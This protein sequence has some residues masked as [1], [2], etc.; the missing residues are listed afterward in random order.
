MSA[1]ASLPKGPLQ[2]A[3]VEAAAGQPPTG[4][5]RLKELA[6][7][8]WM[9][10]PD[11]QPAAHKSGPRTHCA[12]PFGVA[13]AGAAPAAAA[14]AGAAAAGATGPTASASPRPSSAA[15]R[16]RANSVHAESA[17]AASELS[18]CTPPALDA[19]AW[20]WGGWELGGRERGFNLSRRQAVRGTAWKGVEGG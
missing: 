8:A 17:A 14:G 18:A 7:Q 5:T 3:G 15:R 13:A 16:R 20:A 9:A 6:S 11:L 1:V 12:A 2:R 19:A 10:C 4:P